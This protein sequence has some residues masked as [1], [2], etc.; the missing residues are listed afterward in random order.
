MSIRAQ[1]WAAVLVSS[2]QHAQWRAQLLTHH[3]YSPLS[4]AALLP[5]TFYMPL[6]PYIVYT[7]SIMYTYYIFKNVY[8]LYDA[9][10]IMHIL[11]ACISTHNIYLFNNVYILYI[12]ECIH[13]MWCSFH[14]AHSICHYIC[15]M[16]IFNN[17][18]ILYF[19]LLRQWRGGREAWAGALLS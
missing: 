5:C 7:Y 6:Y 10:F 19:T 4:A 14:H 17:V 11:Y 15:N 3:D 18:Y 2:F 8:I 1:S 16:Y 13:I 12:Q 9:L